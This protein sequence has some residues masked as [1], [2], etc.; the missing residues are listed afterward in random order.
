M[1]NERVSRGAPRGGGRDLARRFTT[2]FGPISRPLAGRRWFRLWG[3][4]HHVGRK[5][6][7]TYATPVVVR[8][9]ADGFVI[10]LP[11]GEGTQWVRNL[12]AAGGGTLRWDGRDYRFVDPVIVDLDAVADSFRGFE[13][14]VLRRGGASLVRVRDATDPAADRPNA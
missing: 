12:Q 2:L 11:F 1:A 7:R 13:R 10:P 6:G 9:T 3:V 4:L 8:R 5:S 14:A